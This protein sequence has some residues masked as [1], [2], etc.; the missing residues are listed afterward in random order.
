MGNIDKNRLFIEACKRAGLKVQAKPSAK[1]ANGIIIRDGKGRMY[2]IDSKGHIRQTI[3]LYNHVNKRAI[4]AAVLGRLKT[5]S[6][7]R[8]RGVS[9]KAS[10]KTTLAMKKGIKAQD[11]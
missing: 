4:N 6:G 10:F 1:I 11:D 3:P 8:R 2:T 9:K 5:V 7:A